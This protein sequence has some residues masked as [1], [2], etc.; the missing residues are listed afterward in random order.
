MSNI[1]LSTS[2]ILIASRAP[3]SFLCDDRRCARCWLMIERIIIEV[4]ENG[5]KNINDLIDGGA[6]MLVYI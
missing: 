4:S 3:N 6:V 1:L 5:G 2:Y